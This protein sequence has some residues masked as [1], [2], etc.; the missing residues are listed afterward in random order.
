YRP[1]SV[2]AKA[3]STVDH[4]SGGRVELGIGSCWNAW[5]A[6]LYGIDFPPPRERNERPAEADQRSRTMWDPAKEDNEGHYYKISAAAA[7]RAPARRRAP[8]PPLARAT[9]RGGGGSADP[10]VRSDG[11]AAPALGV[12]GTRT[13]RC[14]SSRPTEC[15]AADGT[16]RPT[17]CRSSRPGGSVRR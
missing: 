16:C 2:L 4:A 7:A 8:V 9:L 12:S 13:S 3:A 5:E 17:T 14:A 1:P 6:G 15:P 10:R 11:G